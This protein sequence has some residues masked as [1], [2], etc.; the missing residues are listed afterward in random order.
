MP[1]SAMMSLAGA[2]FRSER[3]WLRRFFGLASGSSGGAPASMDGAGD[4]G[5]G[6]GGPELR[7]GGGG[8]GGFGGGGCGGAEW[9]RG[10]GGGGFPGSC[11][12]GSASPS[13]ASREDCG[14]ID[15]WVSAA[16]TW[17]LL[18]L[19]TESP[20]HLEALQ[21]HKASKPHPDGG[22]AAP[23]PLVDLVCGAL[24]R[25]R[26]GATVRAALYALQ[27]I[28]SE[29][30]APRRAIAARAM[31]R[32]RELAAGARGLELRFTTLLVLL[33]LSTDKT[34][35][36]AVAERTLDTLLEVA[37]DAGEPAPTREVCVSILSNL[38]REPTCQ[39]M[40]YARLLAREA[41][42]YKE[43][44][45][46]FR[47]D[48]SIRLLERKGHG[49]GRQPDVRRGWTDALPGLE[50]DLLRSSLEQS[51]FDVARVVTR[52]LK[53]RV[54]R[55]LEPEELHA[56]K[57]ALRKPLQSLW[58][59]P[60]TKDAF[61][62][63]EPMALNFTERT[64]N[65]RN[66]CVKSTFAKDIEE[67]SRPKLRKSPAGLVRAG[68]HQPAHTG[69]LARSITCSIEDSRG[70]I[71]C[72]HTASADL[73]ARASL[74]ERAHTLRRAAAS[75][76]TT[77]RPRCYQPQV[78]NHERHVVE[79]QRRREGCRAA[80]ERRRRENQAAGRDPDPPEQG[81]G[82]EE[83]AAAAS[84]RKRPP[85]KGPSPRRAP[86][87]EPAARALR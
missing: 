5:G 80:G 82:R 52:N 56:V 58:N 40:M 76:A 81:D 28:S 37:N 20:G 83:G 26:N 3:R 50:E 27:K 38:A 86:S 70:R 1:W 57:A 79:D 62:A 23:P 21:R 16:A 61:Y 35:A 4:R 29:K 84:E 59:A 72:K 43:P 77:A 48:Q 24:H 34:A 6:S 45:E 31:D 30:R 15:G 46:L 54:H 55:D 19:A 39:A 41:A 44:K 8:G 11:Q 18:R 47:D 73:C 51:T 36:A 60:V 17:L 13:T 10:G 68:Q 12:V 71:V 22:A 66:S 42:A 74:C 69:H 2:S 53:A 75:R 64:F 87:A 78:E 49:S 67:P 33:N 7:R 63:D 32:L 9:R 25:S 65:P 14:T 85:Q